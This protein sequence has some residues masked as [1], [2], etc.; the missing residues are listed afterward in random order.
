MLSN[1]R[2]S[3]ITPVSL[4][5]RTDNGRVSV[6]NPRPAWRRTSSFN[7]NNP[8]GGDQQQ[9]HCT[10]P[11]VLTST[12]AQVPG[13]VVR[14]N[15]GTIHGTTTGSLPKEGIKI[16]LKAACGMGAEVRNL[17]ALLYS[18]REVAAERMVMDCVSRGGNAVVGLSYT[19]GE[20][21]GCVT[22]SV[23]GTAVFV[24]PAARKGGVIQEEDP[25]QG[26]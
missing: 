1:R 2:T 6:C 19:E 14:K 7:I 24:E 13:Y 23:Q 15:I 26:S 10:S 25:F 9:P 22:V 11:S 8:D 12:T 16:W 20:M 4:D 17:T 3:T 5:P 21:M 18:M